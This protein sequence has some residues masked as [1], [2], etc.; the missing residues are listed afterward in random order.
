MR[1]IDADIRRTDEALQYAEYLLACLPTAGFPAR[2]APG[3]W[4]APLVFGIDGSYALV[5]IAYKFD[6]KVVDLLAI[7]RVDFSSGFLP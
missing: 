4:I 6:D 3:I 5:D 7:T 2:T 1:G